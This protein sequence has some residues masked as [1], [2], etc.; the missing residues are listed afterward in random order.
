MGVTESRPSNSTFIPSHITPKNSTYIKKD[1]GLTV[2]P[3]SISFN[4][5]PVCN[6]PNNRFCDSPKSHCRQQF[7]K[8][9]NNT[10]HSYEYSIS[11]KPDPRYELNITPSKGLIKKGEIISIS[12]SLK[13]ICTLNI[14]IPVIIYS[15][16]R[17]SKVPIQTNL[18]IRISSLESEYLDYSE[19]RFKETIFNGNHALLRK[20]I[21]RGR[22]VAVK[23]YQES[24][25]QYWDRL[26]FDRERKFLKKSQ[27]KHTVNYIGVCLVQGSPIC[28]VM[29]FVNG[30]TL[31]QFIM[32]KKR[33]LTENSKRLLALNIVSALR[34]IHSRGIYHRDLK[35]SNIMV[36]NFT[37]DLSNIELVL[38]DFGASSSEEERLRL[39]DSYDAPGTVTHQAPEGFISTYYSLEKAD[40]YSVGILM[41]QIFMQQV[42]F[43]GIS[44]QEVKDNVLQGKRPFIS[45]HS[46]PKDIRHL[47][48]KCWNPDPEKRPDLSIVYEALKSSLQPNQSS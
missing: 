13:T 41:W 5:L 19:F 39:S 46:I 18:E 34:D 14:S 44:D 10:V 1:L 35:A 29:E 43:Y 25:N 33:T 48:Q 27:G 9:N 17:S 11:F 24:S 15:K 47:I 22:A 45:K 26:L 21:Y 16:R 3:S 2:L 12:I 6:H 40:T 8:L 36:R 32:N 7:V 30:G 4:E 31:H 23:V 42:P 37:P 20:A 38:V 28:L